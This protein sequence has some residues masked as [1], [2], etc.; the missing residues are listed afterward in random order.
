MIYS[1]AL[2]A[3]LATLDKL[4]AELSGLSI[5][6]SVKAMIICSMNRAMIEEF[7]NVLR[8]RQHMTSDSH[9]EAWKSCAALGAVL[10]LSLASP[11]VAG[12]RTLVRMSRS[13]ISTL[14]EYDASKMDEINGLLQIVRTTDVVVEETCRHIER[15]N[16]ILDIADEEM[17]YV[18]SALLELCT[19]DAPKR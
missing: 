7:D 14:P 4:E 6:I 17:Q 5:K 11:V 13:A 8:R 2:K 19:S 1:T 12:A 9:I 18:R 10:Q 16:I 15:V 3:R